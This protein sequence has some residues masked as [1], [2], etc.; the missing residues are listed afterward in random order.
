ML[1]LCFFD[2]AGYGQA[3]GQAGGFYA[4]QIDEAGEAQGGFFT[5]DEVA[6][7]IAGTLDFGTDAAH[8]GLQCIA[9]QPGEVF[10][11]RSMECF[12][13]VLSDG[14]VEIHAAILQLR[15]IFLAIKIL[16]IGA[17]PYAAG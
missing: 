9:C 4:G 12:F 1:R 10:A 13:A 3:G 11:D 2:A 6:G 8:I 14:I 5:Y 17:E 16:S 7:G 15:L